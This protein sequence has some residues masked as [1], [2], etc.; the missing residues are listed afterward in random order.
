MRALK[1]AGRRNSENFGAFLAGE[2]GELEV[3]GRSGVG[4]DDSPTI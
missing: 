3:S 1:R 4:G 2:D